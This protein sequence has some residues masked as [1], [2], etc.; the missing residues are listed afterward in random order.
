[1]SDQPFTVA[2]IPLTPDALPQAAPGPIFQAVAADGNMEG[3]R[4]ALQPELTAPQSR[5]LEEVTGFGSSIQNRGQVDLRFYDIMREGMAETDPEKRGLA[6]R[7]LKAYQKWTE[8]RGETMFQHLEAAQRREQGKRWRKNLPMM[9]QLFSGPDT[10]TAMMPEADRNAFDDTFKDSLDPAR[11]K[12]QAANMRLVAEMTGLTVDQL[13]P[14][15]PAYRAQYAQQAFGTK[16]T[17]D[18]ATF[19]QMAGKHLAKEKTDADLM[20][21]IHARASVLALAGKPLADSMAETKKLAGE[22][23]QEFAPAAR[24]GHASALAQ[25]GD[26]EIKL[27]DALWARFQEDRS[28]KPKSQSAEAPSTG[29]SLAVYASLTQEERNRVMGII[30][31][32]AQDEGEDVTNFFARFGK[33]FS[34]DITRLAGGMASATAAAEEKRIQKFLEKG[35]IPA[36]IP[37][38]AKEIPVYP[39]GTPMR[40]LTPEER[41]YFEAQRDTMKGQRAFL[42]DLPNAGIQSKRFLDNERNGFWDTVGDTVVMAAGSL[43]TMGISMTGIG[44]T[45]S[46]VAYAEHDLATLRSQN[47]DAD[48]ATLENTAYVSGLVQ[49]GVD[50]V[51]LSLMGAR[52]PKLTAWAYR[53]NKLLRYPAVAALKGGVSGAAEF[54]QEIVQDLTLPAVSELADALGADIEGTDWKTVIKKEQ[55]ALGDIAR[56][57]L[58]FGI[59]GGAGHTVAD[60]ISAPKL[61]EL[62]TDREGLALAGH[63]KATIDAVTTEAETNPLAAAETLKAATIETPVEVRRANSKAAV[64]EMKANPPP[65]AVEAALPEIITAEDGQILVR[66]P[67]GTEDAANSMED[68]VAALR[69]WEQDDSNIQEQGIRQMIRHLEDSHEG[70]PDLAAKGNFRQT[71]EVTMADWAKGSKARLDQAYARV[72]IAQIQEGLTPSADEDI[73]LSQ[74]LILG[75]SRNSYG[76]GVTRIAMEVNRAQQGTARAGATVLTPIEEH[77]EGVAK[78]LIQSGKKSLSW[79]IQQIRAMEAATKQGQT[80]AENIGEMDHDLQLQEAAEAFSRLAVANATG[81]IQD[82]QVS[83][84]LKAIFRAIKETISAILSLAADIKNFRESGKMDADFGY[85][86]DVAG[87]VNEDYTGENMVRQMEADM[88]AEAMEGMPEIKSA[89]AGKLPHPETLK[90]NGHPLAGEVAALYDEIKQSQESGAN[91]G[92]RT[93]KA[94]E[95]FLPPGEMVDLDIVREAMNE[96]GFDFQTPTDMVDSVMLSVGYGK[97]QYG[98][99]SGVETFSIGRATVTLSA[100]TRT[101]QGAEGS[102]TVIGPATFSIAAFHGTPHKVDKFSLDKIGTGEGAQAY[103]WG[104]YFADSEKVAEEYKKILG[105]EFRLDGQ[106]I[107]R[108]G[109]FGPGH[110]RLYDELGDDAADVIVGFIDQGKDRVIDELNDPLNRIDQDTFE[111]AADLVDRIESTNSGNLYRVELDVEDSEL[112]DWDKPLSE[113][114]DKVRA[115]LGPANTGFGELIAKGTGGQLVQ[116]LKEVAGPQETARRLLERGIPGIRYLDGNSRRSGAGSY[117]YVMFDDSRI[118]ITEENGTPVDLS[119]ETFSISPVKLSKNDRRDGPQTLAIARADSPL[120]TAIDALVVAPEK[121]A[122]VYQRMAAKVR[123]IRQRFDKKRLTSSLMDLLDEEDSNARHEQLKDI[124]TLEVVAKTLPPAIRG[125]LVGSFRQMD[126]LKSAKGREDYLIR[127]LPK[128]EQALENHLQ[129]QFRMAIRREFDRGAIKVSESKTRGGKIGGVAHAIFEEARAAMK[130]KPE[131]AEATAEKLRDELENSPSLTEE[132]LEELDGR[133]AALELFQD[134]DN[135]DSKRMEEGLTLLKDVYRDGRREWLLTLAARRDL[136]LSRIETFKDGLNMNRPIDA[137]DRARAKRRAENP[138]V[139]LD[140]G[141]ME[142]MIS[143]SQKIRRLGELTDDAAVVAVVEEFETAMLDAELAEADMNHADQQA[144]A[145]AMRL[146]FGVNTEYGVAKKLRELTAIK[147]NDQV[148]VTKIEGFSEETIKVP[149]HLVESLIRGEVSGFT[150]PDG[151]AVELGPYDVAALEEAWDLFSQM[152]ETDQNRRR[153]VVFTRRK[154]SGIRKTLGAINQLEGLQLWLTM[155]QPDQGTKMDALGFDA[156]TMAELETWLKP[157]TKALGL[158]MV[159]HMK[160]DQQ[161]LDDLHRAEKGVGLGLVEEYFPIRNDVS[162]A[163]NSNMALDGNPQMQGGRSVS[164]LKERVTNYANPAIVNAVSVFLN[165]RAQV[166]FWK[167][168]VSAMREWGGVIR[169]DGM[170]SAIKTRMGETYYEALKRTLERIESGGSL[171]KGAAKA[172]KWIKHIMKTNALGILGM[173]A[174]TIWINLTAALNVGYEVRADHLVKGMLQVMKRPESFKDAWNS[175]AIR[176]RLEQGAT[177]EAQIGKASGPSANPILAIMNATAE[178]GM[179]PINLADTGANMLGAVVVWEM[180]RHEALRAKLDPETAKTMADAK[181]ERL[182]LR[183]AQ[184]ATRLAKSEFEQ[185]ILDFPLAAPLAMFISEPRKTLAIGYMAL[186]ELT[187]GK[188]TYGKPMAAQQAALAFVGMSAAVYLMR[189][190]FAAFFKAKDDEED[191]IFSRFWQR[192]SDPKAWAYAMTGSQFQAV[193]VIGDAW[194]LGMAKLFDQKHFTRS[195]SP[196]T[197]AMQGAGAIEEVFGDVS[198]GKR[199]EAMIKVAQSLGRVVPG[200]AVVAQ[201][202]NVAEFGMDAAT[203]NGFAFSDEDRLARIKARYQAASK[204][205]DKQL[206]KTSGAD[207]KINKDVQEKKHRALADKLRS[208]LAPLTDTQRK[209][210]FETANLPE[211]VLKLVG[212]P[213]KKP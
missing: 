202:A 94:N 136:R 30:S 128:I 74:Y 52:M 204:A 147:E 91:Q 8:R 93:R 113:Q 213:T 111:K 55:A 13:E 31:L 211:A 39:L 29:A 18:D 24:Q 42:T 175:P 208:E 38:G 89:I 34:G 189:S 148:P 95:F 127:L 45:V 180:T 108:G 171:A 203:S 150:N 25:F 115:A 193:P 188:G 155:R 100:E 84:G 173:R 107:L 143:N 137:A 32:R 75:S 169:D 78:Y 191:E 185:K 97:P 59:V 206:G 44:L 126:M 145:Q 66:Y 181:V 60:V 67:D 11:D 82:S 125:K 77:A 54:G 210:F 164:S 68:A 133:I 28:E 65:S 51:Q 119:V 103:G 197:Q 106:V 50:R 182:L 132:R 158:W 87:G 122:E 131:Q 177:F 152:E 201:G 79:M 14:L 112:L 49:A 163:D 47:P 12:M 99:G 80:M 63:T 157:E 19:Y 64:E 6:K 21:K 86:L 178:K 146:I 160:A 212:Y 166:N 123:E 35:E 209:Q 26:V 162:R 37:D 46:A 167:S 36:V 22:R 53:Q 3:S 16:G 15:W 2:D 27:A 85:W 130:L 7:R 159:E 9:A 116:G 154:S 92:A 194:N 4:A 156:E 96:K 121:K 61:K 117:N 101:Y 184:P 48:P 170:A 105:S 124:A 198:A 70:S 56:V 153:Q 151:S 23:W 200:G 138:L 134:F 120:L 118:K 174:S 129:N 183:S 5:D 187:T 102:P 139:Q 144:L 72:R 17:V 190:V 176:R 196:I 149:K 192:M 168:H 172:E 71:T 140:E 114:S 186:R 81:K 62:L 141:I 10:M 69:V 83:A 109:N 104:L 205:L 1:M 142:L 43:P 195:P 207:G 90:A 33:S 88:L 57:S 98:M 20:E 179:F 41:T 110:R 40:K 76:A 135:A 161:V 58:L 73:D 199:T 165:N